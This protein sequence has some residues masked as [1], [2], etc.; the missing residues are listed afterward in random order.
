VSHARKSETQGKQQDKSGVFFFQ[1]S[2][3]GIS[4]TPEKRVYGRLLQI[5]VISAVSIAKVGV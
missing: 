1:W 2:Y 5:V 3:A 4:I